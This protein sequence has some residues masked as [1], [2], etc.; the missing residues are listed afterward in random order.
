M[1][2]NN[3]DPVEVWAPLFLTYAGSGAP[4]FSP[5]QVL[6]ENFAITFGHCKLCDAPVIGKVKDHMRK[7]KQELNAWL[8]QRKKESA[9]KSA[10]GLAAARKEKAMLRAHDEAADVIANLSEYGGDDDE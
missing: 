8:S 10:A 6:D 7:H 3:P 5:A 9:K 2:T 1:A 4:K